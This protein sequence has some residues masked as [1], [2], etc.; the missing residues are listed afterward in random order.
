MA[1]GVAGCAV[2]PERVSV[3]TCSRCGRFTCAACA[4]S[5]PC[6]ECQLRQREVTP[7]LSPLFDRL[8]GV[9]AVLYAICRIAIIPAMERLDLNSLQQDQLLKAPALTFFSLAA[10]YFVVWLALTVVWTGWFVVL[11]DWARGRGVDAPSTVAAL[12][13]LIVCGVNLVHPLLTLRKVARASA[14]R[15]PIELW[16]VLSWGGFGLS[17]VGSGGLASTMEVIGVLLCWKIV[18]DFRLADQAWNPR[19]QLAARA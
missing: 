19:A 17:M 8:I 14:V 16:W 3:S 5:I 4:T 12:A 18:R 15:T 7:A 13:G 2:H 6:L 9:A 1:D 11:H 10:V